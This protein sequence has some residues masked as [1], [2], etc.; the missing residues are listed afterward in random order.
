MIEN[1]FLYWEM[2]SVAS[3]FEAR[4]RSHLRMTDQRF[5]ARYITRHCGALAHL[6]ANPE[7]IGMLEK[8]IPGSRFA[9]PGMTDGEIVRW[10]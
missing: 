4:K 6:R 10:L 9:R 3:S 1:I 2:S 5:E 8:W 7:S